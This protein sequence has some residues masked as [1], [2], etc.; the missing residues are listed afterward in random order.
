MTLPGDADDSH[1]PGV[2]AA[3][4][5]PALSMTAEPAFARDASPG[6]DEPGPRLGAAATGRWTQAARIGALVGLDA[7]SLASALMLS[8]LVW[9]GPVRDQ[10]LGLYLALWPV[11]P[12]LLLG[13]AQVGLYPGFGIGLV[14]TVRRYWLVVGFAFLSLAA[15]TFA[16]KVPHQYS[17][18]TFGLTFL[19]SL[20]LLPGLRYLWLTLAHGWRWW[21]E[22]V[23][24]I[25]CGERAHRAIEA[26]Q[27]RP[28]IGYRPVG[29]LESSPCEV[30]AIHGVPVLGGLD[31]A[32][33]LARSG[34]RTAVVELEGG[35]V[36]ARVQELR[37]IFRRVMTIR[38]FEDLPVEGVQIRN[39][40][41][42]LGLEYNNNLLERRNRAV[43]R[44]SDVVLGL[45]LALLATPVT[46]LAAALVR[47]AS[48]GPVLFWHDRV[49][50]GGRR[51]SLPKIRTMVVDA[52]ARLE[53]L[54]AHDLELRREWDRGFKLRSDPRIVPVV[55]RLVRRWSL[56]E[57][58]Q[59]WLVV[60]GRMSL[61][62]PRPLPE[63]H[64][65][66]LTPAGRRLRESVRPGLTGLWQVS[67]RS[68]ADLAELEAFDTYYIRNWSL[69][70]DLYIL[71]KTLY[72]VVN[73]RGAY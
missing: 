63:Y 46:L 7:I 13:F 62:G 16:L 35:E 4:S 61:V 51:M 19:S 2:G 57:L 37:Q 8:A 66:R 68:E 5:D 26:L 21:P 50:R 58:P 70:L 3:A 73:G 67:A 41:G 25:G 33:D 32:M 27:D 15:V 55:G 29:I 30:S 42:V 71:A 49:G 59:L 69:W 72:V 17:R 20:V 64:A 11:L 38:S 43:K 6:L 22:P 53:E 47:M 56:D 28:R 10:P 65:E 9:A 24:V 54:L 45:V 60:L 34:V 31:L 18:M 40:G 1:E 36:D 44:A 14:E 48:S 52:D 39:L 12:I 23:V